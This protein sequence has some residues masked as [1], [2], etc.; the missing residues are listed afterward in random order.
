MKKLFLLMFPLAFL[1]ASCTKEDAVRPPI[2]ETEW[3]K[4]E[5]GIVVASTFN[6]DY[7]VVETRQGYSV[8][9][10]WGGF[11]PVRGAVLYGDHSQWGVRTFY[12][13]SEG[14]LMNADVRDTWLPYFQ[15]MDQMQWYCNP[16]GN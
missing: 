13:R 16:F 5:R 9:R 2:D 14:Y 10:S 3:L 8:M 11:A 1:F 6:C 15:A 12:N 4:K 7:F